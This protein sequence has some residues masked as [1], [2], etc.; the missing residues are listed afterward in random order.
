MSWFLVWMKAQSVRMKEEEESLE[1][2][3]LKAELQ[4]MRAEICELKRE[5]IEQKQQL[6][7]LRLACCAYRSKLA[8]NQ[9]VLNEVINEKTD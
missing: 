5:N 1:V 9:R 6:L 4:D 7:S 2:D 8:K 3:N